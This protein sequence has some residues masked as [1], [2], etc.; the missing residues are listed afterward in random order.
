VS[1]GLSAY[2]ISLQGN[3]SVKTFPPNEDLLVAS[4]FVRS[5]VS[6]G[7]VQ[8]QIPPFDPG[9]VTQTVACVSFALYSSNTSH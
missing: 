1:V 6:F 9:A 2:L 4:L 7:E 5:N 3:N 8:Q